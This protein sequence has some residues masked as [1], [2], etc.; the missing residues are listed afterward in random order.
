MRMMRQREG[1]ESLL[2]PDGHNLIVKEM[3]N[4][5]A[6][7]NTL[8][9]AKSWGHSGYMAKLRVVYCLEP[10]LFILCNI[11]EIQF[12]LFQGAQW[13]SRLLSKLHQEQNRKVR[14]RLHFVTK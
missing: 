13:V 12:T 4:V 14:L 5:A 8:H 10:V 6:P 3:P 2:A 1:C 9:M 11:I 7:D